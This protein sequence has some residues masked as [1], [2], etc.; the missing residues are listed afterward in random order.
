LAARRRGRRAELWAALWLLLKGYRILA[1]GA[2]SR[3]AGAGEIDLVA[4]KGAV[5]AFIEVKAR[6]DPAA[7]AAAIGAEQ[8][9]RLGRG[10]LA[11]LQRR[12]ELATLSP[13]FD[14][15]LLAPWHRPRHMIDAWR[16]DD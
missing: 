15:I 16:D 7:A 3:A 1:R 12:P 10:A 8:R 2:T 4:R 13:R 11:F 5:I 6:S 14:A 9:R